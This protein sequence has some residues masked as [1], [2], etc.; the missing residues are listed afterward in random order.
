MPRG[1]RHGRQEAVVRDFDRWFRWLMIIGLILMTEQVVHAQA[2]P[3][4]AAEA[5]R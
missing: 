4:A 5:V 2:R 3:A 1:R